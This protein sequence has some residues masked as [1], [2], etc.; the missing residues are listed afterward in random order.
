MTVSGTPTLS[1]TWGDLAYVAGSGAN[2]LTFAGLVTAAAGTQ[3]R[4]T[5]LTGTVKGLTGT[6][7]AWSGRIDVS[8]R[9]VDS[10]S[11]PPREGLV[12]QLSI[13]AHLLWFA[14]R[15]AA[16]PNTSAALA[17][18]I[19]LSGV[20]GFVP[21]GGVNGFMGTFDG[22]GHVL[23]GLSV[24]TPDASGRLGLFGQITAPGVVTNLVLSGASVS[25]SATPALVGAV[26]G[27]NLGTIALCSVSGGKVSAGPRYADGTGTALGG[28]CGENAGIVRACRVVAPLANGFILLDNRV[29]ND[30]VGGIAGTNAVSGVLESSY[31]HA[32]FDDVT[33]ENIVRGAVCGSNAGAI[34]RC[35]GLHDNSNYFDGAVGSDVGTVEDTLFPDASAFSG[36]EVCYALNGGVTDGSQPWYQ[37]L[38]TDA[39]PQLSATPVPDAT[40]YPHGTI[41]CNEIVHNWHE[42]HTTSPDYSNIVWTAV[43]SVG[44][45]TNVLNAAGTGVV[46]TDPTC[47]AP[48]Q[49]TWT[50]VPPANEY[51]VTTT[52]VQAG[53]P[54]A[55]GH[56]WGAPE[57]DWTADLAVASVSFTCSRGDDSEQVPATVTRIV[58]GTNIVG[59]ATVTHHGETF[60][61]TRSVTVSP[62]KALQVRLDL[63]G[64]VTLA[65]DVTAT[66]GDATLAVTNAVT[67]D[68][69]GH[70]LTHNGNGQALSVGS[71]GDLTLTN[72]LAAGAVTGGGDHGVYVGSNAVFR[73][74]GGAI[75]GNESNYAGGGVFVDQ[76]GTFT[77]TGGSITNNAVTGGI[78][79]GGGVYVYTGG[80]FEMTGGAI[81]GNSASSGGG[82]VFV[83][84]FGTFEMS[85]G[86]ITNNAVTGGI[87][88]GGG[89][90]VYGGGM[91]TL[92]GGAI[93]GTTA[94]WGGGVYV[95]NGGTFTVSDSPVV[96]GS[97]NSVGA[98]N[99][100]Y[101]YSGRTITVNG[102]SPGARI[103]VTTASAPTASAPVTF[104]TGAAEGE[105]RYFVSDDPGYHVERDGSTLLL[106]EG[107]VYPA[108]LGLPADPT[109]DTEADAIIRANYDAWARRYGS[110]ALGANEA[111][112]LLDVAPLATPIELRIAGIEVVEGGARVRVVATA[113]GEA[114][115]LSQINGVISVSAG[116]A[117][118][119]LA[120]KAASGI[121][122]SA[123]EATIFVPASAGRFV[124]AV[125][126]VAAPAAAE[127]E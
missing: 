47:T 120:P 38:G 122:Y 31:F 95:N 74:Q 68:L 48:G 97:T 30:V 11:A 13:P 56:A 29:K 40:V 15:L 92:N 121:T 2:V 72:S 49:T 66:D 105:E 37:A 89:V 34:R 109:D 16:A 100:V 69:N 65:N 41:Y 43:C 55:L 111:A 91:F 25:S 17:A 67:L 58:D 104:A 83:D 86:S 51:G 80:A 61:D 71:G 50:Y 14:D 77:M 82:G 118:D 78:N 110:D 4:L 7:F 116:D 1:T 123:G 113:G 98:A 126:G 75:A 10:L 94:T 62:W 5:G 119:A 114:V 36:G 23:S 27:R 63:G 79:S 59:T 52:V 108:Y 6:S 81:S 115:D 46:T 103:G 96:F 90:Y 28:V 42:T 106:V 101:L 21:M 99:N 12:Y 39:L 60:T 9:T 117:P 64:T 45:E 22:R 3:L 35:S 76:F 8:G 112:Y 18:D 53:V 93:S 85:G 33:K 70:T 84:Q 26:C 87:N 54:A 102:L 124:K 73:L 127:G 32:R 24:S 44:H 125:I 57:W 88:S 107:A 20:S 19:D